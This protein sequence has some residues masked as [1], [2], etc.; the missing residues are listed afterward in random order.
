MS[1]KHSPGP[2]RWETA[3]PDDQLA[4]DNRGYLVDALGER[5]V[6]MSDEW[7]PIDRRPAVRSDIDARLIAAAPEMLE[8]LR[9]ELGNCDGGRRDCYFKRCDHGKMEE[10]IDRIDGTGGAP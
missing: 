6:F 7:E 4:D 10:L 2:W 3:S 9:R 1:T 8:L 5:V